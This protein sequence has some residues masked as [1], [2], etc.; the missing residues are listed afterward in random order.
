MSAIVDPAREDRRLPVTVLSGFLGAGKTTLLNHLLGTPHGMRIAVVV[1]DMSAINIDAHRLQD[2]AAVS[3]TDYALV[4]MSNGC[5]CCTLREDLLGEV[6]RLAAAGRFD[7]LL[8]ESTGIGEPLPVAETFTFMDERGQVLSDVARLD[9]M[10]TV[11]DGANFM[12]Q[13][14]APSSDQPG[15]QALLVNQVE[16]ADVIVVSKSDLIS[17]QQQ[18]TLQGVLRGLNSRA[19][20]VLASGGA[21]APELLLNTHA[22]DIEQ[23][24]AAPGWLAT[25]RGEEHSEQDAYGISSFVYSS[26]IPF[27]PQRFARFLAE[28]G[29]D[30]ALLRAKG[31]LWLAHR[32]TEMGVLAKAGAAP[33]AYEWSGAWWRF[34]DERSWPPDEAQRAFIRSRW[35][36]EV[37]DCRQELV[38]IGQRLDR[39]AITA[40][41]DACRLSDDEILQGADAWAAYAPQEADSTDTTVKGKADALQ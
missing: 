23:A 20:I 2:R 3:R 22:F 21:V 18:G 19:R 34:L 17:P 40:A 9:T 37:G 27:H 14:T 16:F 5:I 33:M 24:S 4:E 29:S 1:N 12:A 36:E 38:F 13:F 25:L 41:L 32:V 15:L 11:V 39:Q 10:A 31:Y 28:H 8:I 7:Y 35:S 6:A 30:K 26:R